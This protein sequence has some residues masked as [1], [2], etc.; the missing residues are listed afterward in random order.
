LVVLV[1]MVLHQ[2]FPALALPMVAVEE[3]LRMALVLLL[4]VELAVEVILMLLQ[5]LTQVV[6]AVL[7]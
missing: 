7:V 3:V 2:Q 4:R 1:A 6:V 5:Q